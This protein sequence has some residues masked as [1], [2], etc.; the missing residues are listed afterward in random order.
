MSDRTDRA[1]REALKRVGIT[2]KA[3]GVP[4]ALTGGYASWARGGPEPVHDVDFVLTPGDVPDALRVLA[5]AGLRVLQP[6]E[7][8]LVKAFVDEG[9]G[10]VLVDLIFRPADREVT[11]EQ[12]ARAE[13]LR[14]DSVLLPVESATDILLSKALALSE[15]F[16]DLARLFPHARALREQVDWDR[17]RTEAAV[18][19]FARA[20]LSV[21]DDL[22][23]APEENRLS[24]VAG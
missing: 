7:D 10:E 9:D 4:F 5:A 16:C 20:F 1:M 17:L 22:G 14:V 23:I 8:W 12:L 13:E 19:P 24:E 21:C 11:R 2:L 18:S 15:H 6:P 3:A